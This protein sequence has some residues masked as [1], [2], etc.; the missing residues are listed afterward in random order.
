MKNRQN[1]D[2]TI[3][4]NKKNIFNQYNISKK[5]IEKS[6]SFLLPFVVKG[7][8]I[9]YRNDNENLTYLKNNINNYET[10]KKVE[11]LKNVK[12]SNYVFN[13]RNTSEKEIQTSSLIKTLSNYYD[14]EKTK[15]ILIKKAN[16][17]LF[18]KKI[19][20]AKL[21][22]KSE[23]KNLF[24]ISNNSLNNNSFNLFKYRPIPNI[25]LA[26]Y[27]SK[28]N[29]N[30]LTQTAR[31]FIENNYTTNLNRFKSKVFK[32]NIFKQKRKIDKL[33]YNIKK[34]EVMEIRKINND[35]SL[36]KAKTNKIKNIKYFKL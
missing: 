31:K 30:T 22:T 32:Y 29:V 23:I 35:L 6:N 9:K 27:K 7:K 1:S 24:D 12:S 10:H 18:S 2:K 8:K 36:L 11:T 14:D 26:S 16:K 3:F 25:N 28:S 19:L 15:K 21:N 34:S 20:K 17:F 33:L 4:Y 13:A 5:N